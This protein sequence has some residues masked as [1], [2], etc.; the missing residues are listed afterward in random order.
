[1]SVEHPP[2][3]LWVIEAASQN[4][5]ELFFRDGVC[6][7]RSQPKDVGKALLRYVEDDSRAPNWSKRGDG[8]VISRDSGALLEAIAHVWGIRCVAKEMEAVS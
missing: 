1:M 4:P 2:P 6:L 3:P 8:W 5:I 7:L